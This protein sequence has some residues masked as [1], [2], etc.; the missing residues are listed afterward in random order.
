M[1]K[2]KIP[3]TVDPAR[4]AQKRLDLDGIIQT[5]LFKRLSEATEGV[6]RDA[7]VSDRKSTRLNSSHAT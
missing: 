3:R 7:Q 6:K 4:T 2:V 1:Q 5:S